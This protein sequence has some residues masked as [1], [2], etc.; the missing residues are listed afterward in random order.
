MFECESQGC[1]KA[2]ITQ[3]DLNKHIKTHSG[4]KPFHCTH[5]GCE[6]VYTTAHHLKVFNF[7]KFL[8]DTPRI[9]IKQSSSVLM[10]IWATDRKL[11]NNKIRIRVSTNMVY[12]QII[13]FSLGKKNEIYHH[14]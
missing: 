9:F 12:L 8:V 7:N 3:S 1:D 2:F 14:S 5:V 4:M 6:K 13:I 10:K 11:C